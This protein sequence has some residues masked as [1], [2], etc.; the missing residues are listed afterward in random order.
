MKFKCESDAEQRCEVCFEV[1][2]DNYFADNTC[3]SCHD[4][5]VVGGMRWTIKYYRDVWL[6]SEP[7]RTVRGHADVGEIVRFSKVIA[8]TALE[9]HT[10]A[11]MTAS[12]A[13]C[14]ETIRYARDIETREWC[15]A[16]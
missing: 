2:T 6:D 16:K 1:L 4:A 8:N 3:G 13:A 14:T 11:V 7:M 5:L 9:S 12:C 10:Y 15:L